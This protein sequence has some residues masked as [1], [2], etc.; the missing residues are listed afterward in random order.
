MVRNAAWTAKT[1][2]PSVTAAGL[3]EASA[4]KAP[5]TSPMAKGTNTTA[6]YARQTPVPATRST[7]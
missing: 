7:V 4:E 3:A 5:W 2:S 1:T 6:A